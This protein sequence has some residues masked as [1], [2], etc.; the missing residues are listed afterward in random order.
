MNIEPC[1]ILSGLIFFL[2]TQ[3]EAFD[4]EPPSSP[5]P[6]PAPFRAY[7]I[8]HSYYLGSAKMKEQSHLAKGLEGYLIKSKANNEN[9]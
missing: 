1:P 4:K 6:P 9:F 2:S 3:P 8:P 5:P 7:I